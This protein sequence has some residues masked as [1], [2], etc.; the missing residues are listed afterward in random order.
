MQREASWGKFL[1]A[2]VAFTAIAGLCVWGGMSFTRSARSIAHYAPAGGWIESSQVYRTAYY[3]R[4]RGLEHTYHADVRFRY[5]VGGKEY[6]GDRA[7]WDTSFDTQAAAQRLAGRY[8]RGQSVMVY[9]NPV[10]P[11]EA[12]L[13]KTV[14]RLNTSSWHPLTVL[15]FV[16]LALVPFGV[17]RRIVLIM[18]DRRDQA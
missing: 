17:I 13:D 16:L 5:T 11:T 10:D 7:A 18:L 4:N 14:S 3:D 1:M 12:V 9:Y 15:G 6:R 2:L 8:T